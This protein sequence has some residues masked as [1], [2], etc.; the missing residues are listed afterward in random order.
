MFSQ[1][2]SHRTDPMRQDRVFHILVRDDSAS[3]GWRTW[4]GYG[5]AREDTPGP[6]LGTTKSRLCGRCKGLARDAIAD[7]AMSESEA[8]PFAYEASRSA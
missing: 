4:C 6:Y 7:E 2:V 5:L 1:G 8:A 3:T